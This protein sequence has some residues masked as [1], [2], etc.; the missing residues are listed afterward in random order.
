[1]PELEKKIRAI[2][3]RL[4]VYLFLDTLVW[5]L[6]GALALSVLALVATRLMTL[7]FGPFEAAGALAGA[8]VIVALM[9]AAS[10]RRTLLQAALAADER[11]GLRERLSSALALSGMQDP[12][13]AIHA[14]QEDAVR[15][16]A[17]IHPSRDFRY[18]PPR[19]AWQLIWPAAA[20]VGIYL[21]MPS[22]DL[23][24][25]DPESKPETPEQV[26]AREAMRREAAREIQELARKAKEA[27]E[28]EV[29]E[30]GRFAAELER[31]AND[32]YLGT[33][34]KKAAIAELSRLQDEVKLEKQD[35]SRET[36]AFRQI[37]GLDRAEHTQD[38][39]Q[40]LKD[41]NFDD[42]AGKMDQ[43]ASQLDQMS[44]AEKQDLADEL[45]ALAD[46][47]KDNPE[48]S[49]ALRQAAEA[50]RQAAQQ[51]QSGQ[52][53]QQG[54][55]GQQGQQGQQGEQGQQGQQGQQGAQQQQ[56]GGQPQ[57]QQGSQSGQ[58]GSQSASQ[59]MQQAA[60]QMMNQQELM[61]QLAKLD[62]LQ[63]QM[64]G[65]CSS[66]L[67]QQG[68]SGSAGESGQSGQQQSGQQ[69]QQAG[70]QGQQGSQPGGQSQGQC[71]GEGC[72]GNHPGECQGSGQ[73]QW[74]E[75][76]STAESMGT[77]GPGR[78]RGTPPQ[79][80][81]TNPQFKDEMIKGEKNPGEILAVIEIDAPA[82]KGESNVRYSEIYRTQQQKA[83]DSMR[84]NEI[85][86]G[87]RNFVR[88]YFD[89]IHPEG[90]GN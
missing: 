27:E 22:V 60:Q 84:R 46:Q 26:S 35:I 42:A 69:G 71:Q 38:M 59:A 24:A 65:S 67:N 34:D 74:R 79:G 18:R 77:G 72:D 88:D 68:Q 3:R 64:Q 11:L 51:Q 36:N 70:Q 30:A 61:E 48:T 25:Q 43:L 76:F 47:L 44:G 16:A 53:Q 17:A 83:A 28:A 23:F 5:T 2:R 39:Q 82:V 87:Y 19:R 80:G 10:R 29:E 7:P 32:L 20:F 8:A 90:G 57:G 85:P 13:G 1:M 52:Q 56:A 81:L 73:G 66:M 9:I 54:G 75:G 41:Q 50:V 49:E 63:Q 14:L 78:G 89:A 86:A 33:K 55:E 6:L 12:S 37:R 40:D 31:L 62:Q 45:E 15:H 4:T 21:W 58:Q